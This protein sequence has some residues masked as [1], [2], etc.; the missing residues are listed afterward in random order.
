MKKLL[1]F[2]IFTVFASANTY[3]DFN[4]SI[5]TKKYFIKNGDLI[6]FQRDVKKGQPAL[7][8]VKIEP[9]GITK[10]KRY[11]KPINIQHIQKKKLIKSVVNNFIEKHSTLFNIVVLMITL[12]A[13]SVSLAM[14]STALLAIFLI[15]IIPIFLIRT[16]PS[17]ILHSQIKVIQQAEPTKVYDR[18]VLLD[19]NGY[20]KK[21]I[22]SLK[23]NCYGTCYKY[24]KNK[25]ELVNFYSIIS[26]IKE[27]TNYYPVKTDLKKIA[28]NN[29][30]WI[31][32]KGNTEIE[33]D[34]PI[35]FIKESN[36]NLEEIIKTYI[37][38]INLDKLKKENLTIEIYTNKGNN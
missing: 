38:P 11:S 21:E 1:L 35:F 18:F 2:F 14:N 10:I 34:I 6:F 16:Y 37:Y 19:K 5:K 32:L 29:S 31:I 13:I 30:L 33:T 24:F 27:L 28:Y 23:A 8:E 25:K 26:D 12:I 20:P 9:L 15:P 36:K 7:V 4:L 17:I 22:L 3:P